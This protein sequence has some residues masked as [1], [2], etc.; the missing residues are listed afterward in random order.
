[1]DVYHPDFRDSIAID[2]RIEKISRALGVTFGSYLE[3]EQFYLHAAHAAG[4]NGL[5]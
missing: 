5:G 2:W 3:E 4:L 1:M